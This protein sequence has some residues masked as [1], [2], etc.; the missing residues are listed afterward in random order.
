MR[1]KNRKSLHSND[2]QQQKLKVYGNMFTHEALIQVMNYISIP[3]TITNIN[4]FKY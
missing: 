2:F 3:R 4:T 1:Y